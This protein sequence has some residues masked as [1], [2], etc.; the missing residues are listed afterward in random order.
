[1]FFSNN[2]L[3]INKVALVTTK[4][5]MMKILNNLIGKLI[6]RGAMMVEPQLE[7]SYIS[8]K[9]KIQDRRLDKMLV[10]D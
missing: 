10:L 5:K 1:M 8:T 7:E 4:G 6:L 2:I 9:K 3:N